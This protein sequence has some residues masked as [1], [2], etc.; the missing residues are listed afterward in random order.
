VS[1]C[2][3]HAFRCMP[4]TNPAKLHGANLAPGMIVS[5]VQVQYETSHRYFV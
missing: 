2:S 4:R 1:M 3:S 5:E